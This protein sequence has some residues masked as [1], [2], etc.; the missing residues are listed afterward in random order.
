MQNVDFLTQ[1]LKCYL[2]V[3]FLFQDLDSPVFR[4]AMHACVEV[5]MENMVLSQNLAVRQAAPVIRLRPV[6]VT[7][8]M[9][10]SSN[11]NHV[12]TS[13]LLFWRQGVY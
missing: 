9:L 1:W 10:Y 8:Q 5:V 11:L 7:W 4:Q 2:D 6:G 13:L 3:L 12:K